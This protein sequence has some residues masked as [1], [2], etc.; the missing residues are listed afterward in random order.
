[1][2]GL[3]DRGRLQAGERVLINGA[4]GGVGTLAVQIAKALGQAL[5]HIA[6]VWLASRR[7]CHAVEFFIAKLENAAGRDDLSRYRP[8]PWRGSTSAPTAFAA[9]SATP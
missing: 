8:A 2:Q 7:S 5:A 6:A 1:L 4:S 3:R 9:S